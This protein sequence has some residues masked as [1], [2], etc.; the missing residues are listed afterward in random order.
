MTQENHLAI[1]VVYRKYWKA[2]CCLY[3]IKVMDTQSCINLIYSINFVPWSYCYHHVL[4]IF[5]D[6]L[7][8]TGP[9]LTH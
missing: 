4:V 8:S 7:Q 1:T 2:A 9:I 5:Y 3:Y 6:C